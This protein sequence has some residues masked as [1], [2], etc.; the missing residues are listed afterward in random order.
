MQ[1]L[2][3]S[4]TFD[5]E[6]TDRLGPWFW[7]I[8]LEVYL[9]VANGNV[10]DETTGIE[11]GPDVIPQVPKDREAHKAVP[12]AACDRIDVILGQ[13]EAN[14]LYAIPPGKNGLDGILR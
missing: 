2:A 5:W 6:S 9:M 1:R 4:A 11:N 8:T 10:S 7:E 3:L 14:R 12:K 13:D